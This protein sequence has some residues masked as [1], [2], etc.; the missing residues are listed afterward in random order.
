M[1]DIE[2]TIEK[3]KLYILQTRSGENA[4]QKAALKLLQIW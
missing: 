1:Q 2:F 3:G 4:Q